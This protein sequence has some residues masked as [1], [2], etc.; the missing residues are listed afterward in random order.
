ML[1]WSW[2]KLKTVD[3][4][5]EAILRIQLVYDLEPKEVSLET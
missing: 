5:M 4:T 1:V 2:P 3:E